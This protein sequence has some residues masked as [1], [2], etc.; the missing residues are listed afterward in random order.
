MEE[1]GDIILL[2]DAEAAVYGDLSEVSRQLCSE[3]LE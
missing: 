3:L 2:R 1:Y